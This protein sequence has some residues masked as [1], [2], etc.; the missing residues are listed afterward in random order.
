MQAKTPAPQNSVEIPEDIIC[1]I[2]QQIMTDPVMLVESGHTYEREA[3]LAHL[4]TKKTDPLT[5][6]LISNAS[7][8]PNH[9]VKKL[10]VSF[11]D[12]QR[13]IHP[14]IDQETYLPQSLIES[15]VDAL[16]KNNAKAFLEALGKD[17][18]LLKNTLREQKNLLMLGCE[19]A[20]LEILKLILEKLANSVVTLPCMQADKGRSL[21]F[22]AARRLGLEGAKLL[23]KAFQWEAT[24][25]QTLLHAAVKENDI[26]RVKVALSFSACVLEGSHQAYTAKQQEA[27]NQQA[28]LKQQKEKLV[29][30]EKTIKKQQLEIKNLQDVLAVKNSEKTMP[31]TPGFSPDT[32]KAAVVLPEQD[33]YEI[34]TQQEPFIAALLQGDLEA[35]KQLER[36]GALLTESNRAWIYPLVA[37]VYGTNLEAVNYIEGK[38]S[39]EE[40]LLQWS[41]VDAEKAKSEIEKEMLKLLPEGATRGDLGNWF[42]AEGG[43]K[44]SCK[45]YDKACVKS[46]GKDG[47]A[48]ENWNHRARSLKGANSHLKLNETQPACMT[49]GTRRKGKKKT[50][51]QLIMV[52][53]AQT[54]REVVKKIC[55]ALNALKKEVETKAIKRQDHEKDRQAIQ[56]SQFFFTKAL[57]EGDLEAA[58][59]IEWY[60]ASLTEPNRAGLYP[61]VA[62]V[63]GMNLEAIRYIESGLKEKAASQWL[64]VD[65]AKIKREIAYEMPQELQEGATRGDLSDWYKSE[66]GHPKANRLYDSAC[67]KMYAAEKW[68]YPDW[69]ERGKIIGEKLRRDVRLAGFFENINWERNFSTNQ[70]TLYFP[71]RTIHDAVVKEIRE[72]LIALEKAVEA[73]TKRAATPELEKLTSVPSHSNVSSFFPAANSTT[74]IPYPTTTTTNTTATT[75]TTT[76]TLAT[77]STTLKQPL[78]PQ[79]ESL[80]AQLIAVLLKSDLAAAQKLELAGASFF[81]QN[82]EGLYPLVAAVY[83]TNLDAVKYIES[84]LNEAAKLQWSE[85][86]VEKAKSEIESEM[87]KELR[88]W[89]T[90]AEL[91][92][93]YAMGGGMDRKK[94]EYDRLCLQVLSNPDGKCLGWEDDDWTA[95]SK[96]I[97]VQLKRFLGAPI[98][99]D[100]GICGL[101]SPDEKGRYN[102]L[103]CPSRTEHD[104]AVKKI[105]EQLND[106]RKAVETKAK[107][108][109]IPPVEKTNM[110]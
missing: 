39:K 109:S 85:V 20:S 26:E 62:A 59:K 88:R 69:N 108:I 75:T 28:E 10:I 21:W 84:K 77:S 70:I 52:P 5:N 43:E 101:K 18:R 40:A 16:Q 67:L 89:A 36:Q 87:P 96:S 98:V 91:A 102:K 100:T 81:Y 51:Q 13:A 76:T 55:D 8:A 110:M 45:Q 92:A 17:S 103:L 33:L 41:A 22:I 12:K 37:A 30:H 2:T 104:A 72:G 50:Y 35:A 83:G 93:W 97:P 106:L 29:A 82:K 95:R 14:T 57:L 15:V 60:G 79:Q 54:H 44:R 73:K 107:R 90:N 63:Y 56:K 34:Q 99:E 3:I 78:T 32:K 11:L 58:K 65:V 66:A 19:L 9:T 27:Q 31:Q 46:D 38:L 68:V 1:P 53:S 23:S 24:D 25:I 71:S 105:I 6:V 47:W 61:L 7:I 74:M 80:Q 4:K 48:D 86:D 49:D 94:G 64:L 42:G